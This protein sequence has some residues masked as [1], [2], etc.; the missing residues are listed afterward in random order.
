MP[1][2]LVPYQEGVNEIRHTLFLQELEQFLAA[3]K[4][5]NNQAVNN[6]SALL[7]G[8]H[9]CIRRCSRGAGRR[10]AGGKVGQALTKGA[11]ESGLAGKTGQL[12]NLGSL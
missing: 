1:A 4:D 11:V 6:G 9:G 8:R 2:P 10:L 7:K 5:M 3:R 12:A